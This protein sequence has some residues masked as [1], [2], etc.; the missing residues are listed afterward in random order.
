MKRFKQLIYLAGIIFFGLL[1][2]KIGFDK[3]TEVGYQNGKINAFE[4]MEN[5]IQYEILTPESV[6]AIDSLYNLHHD[7]KQ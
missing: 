1:C 7:N 4:T 3:G 2:S 5:A 6:S